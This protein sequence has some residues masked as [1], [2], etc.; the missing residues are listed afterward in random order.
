[1]NS[2][3][4]Q[5]PCEAIE[6]LIGETREVGKGDT[7]APDPTGVAGPTRGEPHKGSLRATPGP[8]TSPA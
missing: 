4:T 7:I 5:G 1:M 6:E 2:E 8:G 3:D